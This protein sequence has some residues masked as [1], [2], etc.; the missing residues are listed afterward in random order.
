MGGT[1]RL[2]AQPS[3]VRLRS[4]STKSNWVG[5][6]A[7]WLQRDDRGTHGTGCADLYLGERIFRR[8][9][10][11]RCGRADL[12]RR[13]HRRSATVL[14]NA[15]VVPDLENGALVS[16]FYVMPHR[17]WE[18]VIAFPSGGR[19]DSSD[20]SRAL[21]GALKWANGSVQIA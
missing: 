7:R 19:F 20:E 10:I 3:R 11:G 9:G 6:G 13:A 12:R 8:G 21:V 15:V 1:A 14:V 16:R 2:I 18:K 17:S 5:Q 4:W